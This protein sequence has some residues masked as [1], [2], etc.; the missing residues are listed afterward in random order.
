[1]VADLAHRDLL[2]LPLELFPYDAVAGRVW[3]LRASITPYDAAYVGLA[4]LL[5]GPLATLDRRLARAPGTR[6]A[7]LLPPETA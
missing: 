4:E 3:E 6:C 5:G 7:F 1:M 2:R